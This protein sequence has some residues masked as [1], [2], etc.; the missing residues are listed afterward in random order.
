MMQKMP[1]NQSDRL[2]VKADTELCTVNS[3]SAKN[4]PQLCTVVMDKDCFSSLMHKCIASFK[5]QFMAHTSSLHL[6]SLGPSPVY[7]ALP[8]CEVHCPAGASVCI[9]C[10]AGSY[11][12]STG[13]LVKARK[14][15]MAFL[16][17]NYCR[18]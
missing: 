9:K 13:V 18:S 16:F 12:N 2:K 1:I 11:S 10:S 8:D 17:S 3:I 7:P 15:S 14:H 6:N 5:L 4:V